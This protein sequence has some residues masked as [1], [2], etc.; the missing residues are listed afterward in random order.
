[1]TQQNWWHALTRPAIA[2]AAF[3]IATAADAGPVVRTLYGAVEGKTA[4]TE[5]YLGIPYAAPPTGALRWRPPQPPTAWNG[6]RE[7][8]AFGARCPQR[9]TPFGSY[10]ANE[11]CLT[12]NVYTPGHQPDAKRPVMVWIHGGSFIGG[13]GSDYDPSDL[14]ADGNVVV[15]TLNYRLGAF[16]FLALPSLAD[17]SG[18]I[19]GNYGLADQQAALRWVQQ[20]I[21]NF[22]GDPN[23]VT[24]FGESAGGSSVSDQ[25]A[26][27][28]AKGL[29]HKAIIESGFYNPAPP[30][31]IQQE[32]TH[33]LLAASFGCGVLPTPACLR[34]LSA[35]Q[36][37]ASSAYYLTGQ[38][39]PSGL[40]ILGSTLTLGPV[41]GTSIL[42]ASPIVAFAQ[43]RFNKVPVL[44]GTNHDE[45]TGPIAMGLDP[46]SD[47]MDV[48][49]YL[50]ESPI[51]NA[52]FQAIVQSLFGNGALSTIVLNYVGSGAQSLASILSK[53]LTDS[54]FS[55]TARLAD[56]ALA[57]HV[58]VYA[59]EFNDE[60]SFTY[61]VPPS[62]L[63]P[64]YG[65]THFNEVAYI[66]SNVQSVF[67]SLNA[68]EPKF[69]P[70]QRAL[71]TYMRQAWANFARTGNPNGRG[72]ANWP[73]Y[74]GLGADVFQSLQIPA[75]T[76]EWNFATDHHCGIWDPILTLELALPI[77]I[78]GNG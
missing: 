46:S 4:T 70:A 23:N 6:I 37:L 77:G 52:D 8:T 31:V 63:F 1:M 50:R 76:P 78:L 61:L 59:Y 41:R 18:N 16:G 56:H 28:L 20:N 12:L 57:H 26:S 49:G 19:P 21:A 30:P 36:I 68:I 11:D 45:A 53:V 38:N 43:G 65:A 15:V 62:S 54:G 64:S 66:F 5:Q 39:G 58:P 35:E 34:S 22:G 75:S 42:P 71:S 29:F 3:F 32:A 48:N 17:E 55:C 33:A 74:G 67:P 27:P 69:T 51:D 72:V 60:Q 24:L 2:L 7:A 13:A 14:V 73:S 40:D 10:S 44:N 25:L 9:A 47:P